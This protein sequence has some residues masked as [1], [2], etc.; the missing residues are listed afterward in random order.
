MDNINLEEIELYLNEKTYLNSGRETQIYFLDNEIYKL[1]YDNPNYTLERLNDNELRYLASLD[2]KAFNNIIGFIEKEE[3]DQVT[4]KGYKEKYLEH[5]QFQIE[6]LYSDKKLYNLI[7]SLDNIKD[8]IK[9]MSE[10]GF[11]IRNI[12]NDYF[13]KDGKI[14]FNDMTSY[15]RHNNISSKEYKDLLK[16][17]YKTMSIF[18]IGLII[19][20]GHKNKNGIEDDVISSVSKYYEKYCKD[21]YFGDVFKEMYSIDKD[22]RTKKV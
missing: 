8:D 13:Y 11:V 9:L 3:N 22:Y 7:V 12:E 16:S 5:E 18:L 4:I 15:I 14:T 10:N 19:Y 1:F 20:N 17:N 21:K 6:H 2:L